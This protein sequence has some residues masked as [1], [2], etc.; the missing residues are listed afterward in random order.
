M[1]IITILIDTNRTKICSWE[2]ILNIIH[3]S[4]PSIKEYNQKKERKKKPKQQQQQ[5][6]QKTRIADGD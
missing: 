4:K 6:Q 5:Q 3:S 2:I 1:V